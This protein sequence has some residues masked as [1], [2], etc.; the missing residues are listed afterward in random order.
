MLLLSLVVCWSRCNEPS[1]NCQ[2]MC[3][4]KSC[5]SVFL[6]IECDSMNKDQEFCSMIRISYLFCW[7]RDFIIVRKRL[8]LWWLS[9][10]N[11][12]FSNLI[13]IENRR[14]NFSWRHENKK[15]ILWKIRFHIFLTKFSII[16]FDDH[17]QEHPL[18]VLESQSRLDLILSIIIGLF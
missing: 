5:K 2:L 17:V 12:L 3:I 16:R 11:T 7:F 14:L 8:M 13:S 1:L 9:C 4:V 18:N 10:K 6:C 15:L